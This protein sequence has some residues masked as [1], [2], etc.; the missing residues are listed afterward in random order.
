METT[1]VQIATRDPESHDTLLVSCVANGHVP[2]VQM[3]LLT[4]CSVPNG[5]VFSSSRR[6]DIGWSD[7]SRK[8]LWRRRSGK[9]KPLHQLHKNA[10]MGPKVAMPLFL[11]T[12]AVATTLQE[13]ASVWR[14][15]FAKDFDHRIRT[16]PFENLVNSLQETSLKFRIVTT[17][18]AH[19]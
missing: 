4:R 14:H 10:Q 13:V 1:L 17:A 18:K 5:S 11:P 12:G 3:K 6:D 19:W 7:K 16:V 2:S 9:L 15:Q 8:L